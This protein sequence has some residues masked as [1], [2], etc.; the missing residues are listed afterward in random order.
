MG[1]NDDHG[2]VG[3]GEADDECDNE[4]E[5]RDAIPRH[6]RYSGGSANA[7]RP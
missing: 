2:D 4:S 6:L 1:R 3:N 5:T 7:G